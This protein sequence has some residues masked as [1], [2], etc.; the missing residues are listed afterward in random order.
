MWGVTKEIFLP[1]EIVG[2]IKD[3]MGKTRIGVEAS[4]KLNRQEYGI[5]WSNRMDNGGLVVGD[6]VNIDLNIEAVNSNY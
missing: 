1:F 4:L 3:P 2:K 6:V 5:S